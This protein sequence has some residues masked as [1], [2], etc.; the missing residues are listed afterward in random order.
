MRFTVV[1]K[2]RKTSEKDRIVNEVG[3]GFAHQRSPSQL[4]YVADTELSDEWCAI[5]R[6]GKIT[7]MEI[8]EEEG[9]HH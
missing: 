5:T 1:A 3:N 4:R 7:T 6:K 2:A 9:R 8:V